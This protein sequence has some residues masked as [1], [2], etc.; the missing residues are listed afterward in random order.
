MA[1]SRVVRG[2]SSLTGSTHGNVAKVQIADD[3]VAGNSQLTLLN[4][5]NIDL[6]ANYAKLVLNFPTGLTEIKLQ[7]A[8]IPTFPLDPNRYKSLT[9]VCVH[10]RM[11]GNCGVGLRSCSWSN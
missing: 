11:L 9:L 7:N 5:D 2:G 4:I 1:C 6:S 3:F 8:M 10:R